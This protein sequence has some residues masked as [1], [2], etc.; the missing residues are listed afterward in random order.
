MTP[1]TNKKTEDKKTIKDAG[2]ELIAKIEKPKDY[3]KDISDLHEMVDDLVKSTL[4]LESQME[5]VID[6]FDRITGGD[7]IRKSTSNE[8]L[9]KLKETIV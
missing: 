3:D 5:L 6:M 4:V 8:T 1:K 9:D 7:Y 2:V